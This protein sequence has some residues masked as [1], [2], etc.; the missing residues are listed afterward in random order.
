MLAGNAGK[1]V[2]RLVADENG[3]DDRQGAAQTDDTDT[4]GEVNDQVSRPTGTR[5]RNRGA[6]V[7]RSKD[8]ESAAEGIDRDQGALVG[9]LREAAETPRWETVA[10]AASWMAAV[11]RARF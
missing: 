8:L 3:A 6:P 4:V 10:S 1:D 2:T 11:S 5:D 9:G 7:A